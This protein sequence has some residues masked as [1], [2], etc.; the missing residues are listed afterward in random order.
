M[1]SVLTKVNSLM[2]T[3]RVRPGNRMSFRLTAQETNNALSVIDVRMTPGSEPPRHIHEREDETIIMHEGTATFFI[4]DD[5]INAKKGDIIFMPRMVPH[6]FVVT[7]ATVHCTLIATPG[8]IEEFFTAISSPFDQEFIP[9]GKTS[10]EE[11]GRLL[12]TAKAFGM[13]VVK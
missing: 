3:V 13:A 11:T 8:G 6:H 7:S 12:A 9:P 5:I 1:E 2:N 4:A 10:K